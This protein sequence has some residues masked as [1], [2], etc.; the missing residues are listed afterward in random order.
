MYFFIH[1]VMATLLL[2]IFTCGLLEVG[3]SNWDFINLTCF[4][5]EYVSL[6]D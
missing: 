3:Q 4:S 2:F 6:Y 1:L 5:T